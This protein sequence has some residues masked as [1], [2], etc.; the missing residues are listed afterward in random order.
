MTINNTSALSRQ[1][2]NKKGFTLTEIAIVLGIIG[3]ILGA[4]WVAAAGVYANQRT[5]HANTAVLQMVQGI[6]SLYATA[7][8]TGVAGSMNLQLINA[9]IIP[10]D[11]ILSAA[12]GTINNPWPNGRIDILSP[13]SMDSFTIELTQ[14]PRASCINLLSNIAGTS[15]DAGLFRAAA[16]TAVPAVAGV[17]AP[18]VVSVAATALATGA[19]QVDPV[20]PAGATTACSGATNTVQFGFALK[21]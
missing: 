3:L 21:S 1:V 12:A 20:L 10:T 16:T 5:A 2:Q 13:A 7:P 6:R 19:P 4:I 15:R 18:I 17:S 14:V 9:G 11:M 8:T